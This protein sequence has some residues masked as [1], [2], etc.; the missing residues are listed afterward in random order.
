MVPQD[1][2]AEEL[3]TGGADPFRSSHLDPDLY[4][5]GG[6][7]QEATLEYLKSIQEGLD[8]ENVVST[9]YIILTR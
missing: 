2:T 4:V 9:E 5:A 1:A 3:K 8:S 6:Y 7:G